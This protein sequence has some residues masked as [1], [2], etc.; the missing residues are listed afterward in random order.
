MQEA[1]NN[2]ITFK[3]KLKYDIMIIDEAQDLNNLYYESI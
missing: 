3:K 2:Q 1:L